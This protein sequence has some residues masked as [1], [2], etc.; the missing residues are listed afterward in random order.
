MTPHNPPLSFDSA[1]GSPVGPPLTATERRKG[2]LWKWSLAITAVVLALF[3]WQCGSAIQAGR[4]LSNAA[5]QH[6]HEQL[7]GDQYGV[8]IDEADDGFRHNGTTREET[9]RF[10]QVVHA[11]LGNAGESRLSNI[12]VQTM[13]GGT[14]VVTV[15][16]TKFD[17]GQAIES[18]RWIKKSGELLLYGYNI[19]SNALIM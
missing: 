6:F 19:Q 3:I 4:K 14:F 5:V 1:T 7:N 13:P 16:Q 12:T 11:K 9:M 2:V 18:F 17:R 15:Y 10:F 8:I